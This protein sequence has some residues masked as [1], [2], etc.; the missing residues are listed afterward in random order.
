MG[1]CFGMKLYKSLFKRFNKQSNDE[2]FAAFKFNGKVGEN[3]EKPFE[4]LTVIAKKEEWNFSS[5]ELKHRHNQKY[6]ILTNYLNNTFL[7]VLDLDLIAFSDDGDKACFN[8][9]LQTRDDQDIFAT[10]FKNKEAKKFK[11]PDWTFFTFAESYSKK[12]KP[13]GPLPDIA[14]Y[15]TD[16]TDLIFDLS[17]GDGQIEVNYKHIID[18]NQDRLPDI[19]QNNDR[20]ALISLKGAI[21][22]LNDRIRRN[23][24]V[25]IPH[26]YEG[27]IQLLLPLNLISDTK[28][29]IALVIEK[30]KARKI[31]RATTIL[32]M[33]MAYID[34]RLITAPDRDW[35]NP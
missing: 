14:T 13:F 21:E 28:A 5:E 8:T 24:K 3:W 34:A 10:F 9:G 18:E 26:W 30:D 19:L 6:P 25:A 1:V 16:P 20:L 35:L 12:L 33:D 27:E 11:A 15:I 29:D 23:Y 17:Y 32:T 31:Y 4:Q 22:S 2:V 7:R